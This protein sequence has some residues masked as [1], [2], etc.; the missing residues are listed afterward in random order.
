MALLPPSPQLLRTEL[1]LRVKLGPALM[2]VKGFAAA[3]ARANYERACAISEDLGDSAE[4][5]SALWGDWANKTMSGRVHEAARRSN[6]LVLLSRRL[7]Q[8]E[9][10]LQAH[11]SR[12]TNLLMI[13]DARQTR[14]DA[15]VGIGLY[16]RERHRAHRHLYGGHDPGV[17]GCGAGAFAAWLTGHADEAN[18]LAAQT[19]ALGQAIEHPFS[20]SIGWTVATMVAWVARDYRVARERAESA[21]QLCDKHGFVQWIGV[22]M[23]FAGSCRTLQGEHEFGLKLLE[24]GVSRHRQSGPPAHT[25]PTLAAA[26]TALLHAGNVGRANELLLEARD[27]SDKTGAALMQP[28]VLRL[29]AEVLSQSGTKDVAAATDCLQAALALARQQGALALEWR[30]ALS[31]ARLQVAAGDAAAARALLS[32]VRA[33]FDEGMGPPEVAQ[34][35]QWLAELDADAR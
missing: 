19:V 9:Y 24:E 34:G 31:L 29:Q 33:K 30:C 35:L 3:E 8:E 25:G 5:F 21:L 1:E 6:D 17:C 18:R 27:A 11:H 32:H 2:A 10:V 23:V 28:E 13:G 20:E 12:W 22:G 16:D 26:A 7:D 15:L 14:I 4:R